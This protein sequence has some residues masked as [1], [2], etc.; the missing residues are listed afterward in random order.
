[1][2]SWRPR[3]RRERG[4]RERRRREYADA[5][6][7]FRAR[8]LSRAKTREVLRDAL[9]EGFDDAEADEAQTTTKAHTKAQTSAAGGGGRVGG[10]GVFCQEFAPDA[11][12]CGKTPT[13]PFRNSS[14][15]FVENAVEIVVD[16]IDTCRACLARAFRGVARMERRWR[17]RRRLRRRRRA[18]RARSRGSTS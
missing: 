2:S 18:D 4:V 15:F 8:G 1:M 7:F 17:L 10:G 9:A 13:T 16:T 11:R 14:A 5:R 3:D 12:A 6:G